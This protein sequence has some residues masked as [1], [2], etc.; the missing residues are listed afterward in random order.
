MW[1]LLII[2]IYTFR[3]CEKI[4]FYF[5]LGERD[6]M[7]GTSHTDF[8]LQIRPGMAVACGA[9]YMMV[10]TWCT[11]GKQEIVR[12]LELLN[13]TYSYIYGNRLTEGLKLL[14]SIWLRAFSFHASTIPTISDW[15]THSDAR[16]LILMIWNCV[17]WN[18]FY[19]RGA[20]VTRVLM[21]R[22]RLNAYAMATSNIRE[23]NYTTQ[24]HGMNILIEKPEVQE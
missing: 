19:M 5:I 3:R 12:G 15:Y 11:R 6:V 9:L 24:R 22:T 7:V 4:S 20:T 16:M 13:L 23:F 18:A 2:R 1:R 10:L 17:A 8:F 14:D 21:G